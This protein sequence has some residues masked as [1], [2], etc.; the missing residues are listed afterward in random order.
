MGVY[1]DEPIGE[2]VKWNNRR[3]LYQKLMNTN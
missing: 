1:N 3:D 2:Y